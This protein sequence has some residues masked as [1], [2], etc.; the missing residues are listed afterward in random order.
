MYT[1]QKTGW[2]C[3]TSLKLLFACD[4]AIL[5]LALHSRAVLRVGFRTCSIYITWDLVRNAK[6]WALG[7]LI[8]CVRVTGLRETQIDGRTLFMRVFLKEISI[9]IES[10]DR[11]KISPHQCGQ[12]FADLLRA[13][14]EHKGREIPFLSSWAG[15][16]VFR[17]QISNIGAL[18]Y[19][20]FGL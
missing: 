11:V 10:V 7:W 6:S 20:A 12:A 3:I 1:C 2:H 15:A 18:G 8:L 5:L 17:F 16:S 13:W 14:I 19:G 4:S 9:W